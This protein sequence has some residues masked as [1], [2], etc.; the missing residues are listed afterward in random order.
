MLSFRSDLAGQNSF[1]NGSRP[2]TDLLL[3]KKE[4]LPSKISKKFAKM[5]REIAS[6]VAGVAA[7]SFSAFANDLDDDRRHFWEPVL[8]PNSSSSGG[9]A[10]SSSGAAS[11]SQEASSGSADP[12]EVYRLVAEVVGCVL[13]LVSLIVGA[14]LVRRRRQGAPGAEVALPPLPGL[15]GGER[16]PVAEQ[17]MRLLAVVMRLRNLRR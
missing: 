1:I 14:Y 10:P 13:G 11:S 16:P 9:G 6:I 15:G 4:D 2:S 7:S 8:A 5:L 17:V 3:V 12:F